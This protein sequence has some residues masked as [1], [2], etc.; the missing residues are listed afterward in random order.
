MPMVLIIEKASVDN[1][2][3]KSGSRGVVEDQVERTK[4]PCWKEEILRENSRS[5]D[6]SIYDF[7]LVVAWE[8]PLEPR[9]ATLMAYHW[10]VEEI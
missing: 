6:H 3:R 7:V 10:S 9:Y 2:Q 4:T 1:E 8:N 5:R